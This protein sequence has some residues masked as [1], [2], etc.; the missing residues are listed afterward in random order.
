MA[1]ETQIRDKSSA[2]GTYDRIFKNAWGA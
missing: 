1:S 2:P